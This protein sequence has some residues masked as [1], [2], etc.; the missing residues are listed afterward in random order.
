MAFDDVINQR[1]Q[2]SDLSR[3]LIRAYLLEVKSDL[4]SH[5]DSLDLADGLL[6]MTIPNAP[7]SRLQ[8]YRLTQKGRMW[9]AAHGKGRMPDLGSTH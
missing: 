8:K 3:D 4:A 6:E 9:L 7:H 5:V 2:V 1:A